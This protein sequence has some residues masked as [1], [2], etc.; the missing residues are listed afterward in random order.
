MYVC[1]YLCMYLCIYLCMHACMMHVYV[2]MYVSMYLSMYA[3]MHDACLCMYVCMYVCMYLCMYVCMY[4]CM[5]VCMYVCMYMC[6][7]VCICVCVCVCICVCICV[8]VCICICI[9]TYACMQYRSHTH[10]MQ[11]THVHRAIS[12]KCFVSTK[13]VHLTNICMGRTWKI[14]REEY[15]HIHFWDVVGFTRA[16]ITC[17]DCSINGPGIPQ[18]HGHDF[19]I[20]QSG[21]PHMIL[22]MFDSHLLC[23]KCFPGCSPG[24][25][26]G[27][28]GFTRQNPS[29]TREARSFQM[30][31]GQ[32]RAGC[33][34][35]LIWR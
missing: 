3:C 22:Y 27:S 5:Y 34:W 32:G 8:C 35:P 26:P 15:L 13:R 24:Q 10:Q 2:C 1:M 20:N 18:G 14:V 7:Y 6:M 33:S 31:R 4:L 9:C 23:E 21:Q 28:P 29:Q 19:T 17:K 12:G 11:C 25:P 16:F 30:R